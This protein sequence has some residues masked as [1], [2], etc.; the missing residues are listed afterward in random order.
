VKY[1][2]NL[3]ST[4]ITVKKLAEKGFDEGIIVI[5]KRQTGGYGRMKRVWSSNIGGLWFSMLLKPQICS[6]EASKLALLLSI[7]LKRTFETKYKI[8]SEIKWPNDIIVCGKKL[9][10]III[11]TSIENDIINWVV[12]GIGININ[13]D[14]PKYLE[15]KS[16]SLKKILKVRVDMIEFMTVFLSEFEREYLNF[17]KNGFSQFLKEYNDRIAYKYET[18]IIN[19]K[20]SIV[21][22]INLGINDRGGLIV[23]TDYGIKSVMSGTLE[24]MKKMK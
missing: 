9:A 3:L 8:I 15:D 16:V 19:N 1:Y 21:T 6:N 14:L 11:E 5:S 12:V 20:Y 4:Q 22:G 24:T 18:V 2:E 7:I 13:N 17:Q 10:G 23:K